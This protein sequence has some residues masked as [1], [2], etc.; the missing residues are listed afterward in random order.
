MSDCPGV[1]T[2]VSGARVEGP[3]CVEETTNR[4]R[5]RTVPQVYLKREE[6]GRVRCGT[7]SRNQCFQEAKGRLQRL[8]AEQAA[9][10]N[11]P[12]PSTPSFPSADA[13]I[14]ALNDKLVEVEGERD[15]AI[16][17]AI[18]RTSGRR[19]CLLWQVQG[20]IRPMPATRVPRELSEWLQAC[21]EELGQALVAGDE[22]RVMEL[23]SRLSDGA[24]KNVRVDGGHGA[25]RSRPVGRT[26]RTWEYRGVRVG[27][28]HTQ[29][30]VA[31]ADIQEP[32][33]VHPPLLIL[34]R[35]LCFMQSKWESS[36]TRGKLSKVQ[37]LLLA[38]K[39]R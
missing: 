3:A 28:R 31:P 27:R 39:Q 19:P 33:V 15:A 29:D 13:E 17:P 12:E 2:D 32:E 36:R 4:C 14:V 9:A 8:E 22:T 23:S 26:V 11:L 25:V 24:A 20:Q 35:S 34:T 6:G 16:R 7:F 5:T 1:A 37:R 18:S 21:H 10:T 38:T 30:R